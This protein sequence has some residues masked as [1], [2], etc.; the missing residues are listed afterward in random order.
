MFHGVVEKYQ[1]HD[2]FLF[3]VL[4][5][6]FFENLFEFF[7][8]LD[9]DVGFVESIVGGDKGGEEV[10]FLVDDV[11]ILFI[12]LLLDGILKVQFELGLIFNG[13]H[14]VFKHSSALCH[15][16]WN[17][18]QGLAYIFINFKTIWSV[19]SNIF[20]ILQQL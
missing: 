6:F 8:A 11:S 12:N 20:D 1:V 13:N 3:I 18:L 15:P 10:E 5:K 4:L 17:E 9:L 19:F 14:S 16:K 7:L 2:L